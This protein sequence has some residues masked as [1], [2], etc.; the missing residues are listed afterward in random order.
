MTQVN[1]P[2]KQKQNDG[3]REGRVSKCKRSYV[4]RIINKVELYSTGNSTQ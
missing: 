2:M 4:E 1:L 3:H